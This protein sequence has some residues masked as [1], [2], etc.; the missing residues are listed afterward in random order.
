ML[1]PL[2]T[3]GVAYMAIRD[4]E[5]AEKQFKK[6]FLLQPDMGNINLANL[7]LQSGRL[8]RCISQCEAIIESCPEEANVYNIL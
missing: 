1:L 6:I 5:Q 2:Q 7:S 4:F 8:S 3:S